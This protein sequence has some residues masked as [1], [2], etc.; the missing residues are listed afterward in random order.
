MDQSRDD[1]KDLFLQV[2]N[3]PRAYRATSK[4]DLKV[5]KYSEYQQGYISRP[6]GARYNEDSNI[7]NPNSEQ[8][9]K[10]FIGGLSYETDEKS[11]RGHFEKWG[12]IVDCIVMR[13]PQTKKSRGF[14]FITYK[15]ASQLDDAQKNRPHKL[16]G[17]EVETKRAMPRDDPLNQQSVKK[18]F[19]G[20]LKD[21]TTEEQIRE[22]FSGNITEVEMIKDKMTGKSRGFCFVTFDDTDTVDKHVLKRHFELNGRRVEVKKAVSKSDMPYNYNY[23]MM[24]RGGGAYG[25]GGGDFG[26]YGPGGGYGPMGG[27][28]GGGS[29]G[30]RGGF[31]GGN[32]GY[33]GGGGGYG[34]QGWNQG[35]DYYHGGGGYGQG[36][37]GGQGNYSNNYGGHMK[38][39]YGG[40]SYGGGSNYN[41]R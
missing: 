23:P 1:E 9:R 36:G 6:R 37:W 4:L 11:L 8:F 35:G 19:V 40:G 25:R 20:G 24:G 3:T 38:G 26:N 41:R 7:S 39:G 16:D 15:E 29:Y 28:Y 13:D 5:V 21:D 31:G 33:G 17:R 14:G 32:Y 10:L 12:E 2:E 34:N 22:C 30:P 27:G 18:M